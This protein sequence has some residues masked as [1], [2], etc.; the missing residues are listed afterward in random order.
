MTDLR[1]RMRIYDQAPAPDYWIEVEL[2]ASSGS[3]GS[4]APARSARPLLL[5]AAATLLALAVGGAALALSR[6]VDPPPDSSATH[7]AYG[8]DG[9]IFL[10]DAD[11]Q[12]PVRMADGEPFG[13]EGECFSFEG[14]MWS[15][16]G[17]YL[18][19]RSFWQAGCS[20]SVYLSDADGHPVA[21]F[22]GT[23]WLISWSPDSTRVATWVELFETVG[24]Y[25]IDGERQALLSAP[26]GCVGPGDHDPVWSPDGRSVVAAGCEM[27]IDGQT[28][29][30]LSSDDP[31]SRLD[32]VYSPDGTRVAYKTYTED[33]YLRTASLVIADANGTVLQILTYQ[34]D[35]RD[36]TGEV[37]YF[38][39]IVWSPLGDRVAFAWSTSTNDDAS[40]ASELRVLDIASGEETTIAAE[41]GIGGPLA[42][43]PEG[44][45]ILHLRDVDGEMALW[46]ITAAGSDAQLLV[47]GADSGDWQ[48]LP[49]S[50]ALPSASASAER[51]ATAVALVEPTTTRSR[52]HRSGCR[53]RRRRR[54]RP[55]TSNGTATSCS[56]DEAASITASA[57]DPHVLTG[58][59]PMRVSATSWPRY[60][61][62]E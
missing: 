25:A 18:A 29:R 9:D 45:R 3:V 11:G 15:P 6:L 20:G 61:P 36:P 51:A 54:H 55:S 43:S 26:P 27:P 10:A 40:V 33:V 28:P 5:L 46:S 21:S 60:S 23:G 30:R 14:P 2:R 37:V 22:P 34:N 57:R 58:S 56:A 50:S 32:W 35:W 13:E 53:C 49:P 19:Y 17:R 38:D 47:P 42:Y 31:L 8:L 41:P 44:D 16:D 24:I 12:D 1:D 48:P 4:A 39:S 52:G 59:P 7:L 62:A